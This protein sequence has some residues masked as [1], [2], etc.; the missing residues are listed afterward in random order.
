LALKT[1]AEPNINQRRHWDAAYLGHT[2]LVALLLY[3]QADINFAGDK[4]PPFAIAM[5]KTP[6]TI[7]YIFLHVKANLRQR[8]PSDIFCL[9]MRFTLDSCV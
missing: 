5:M 1:K 4:I 9:A 6:L 2:D 3:S 8:V 7:I